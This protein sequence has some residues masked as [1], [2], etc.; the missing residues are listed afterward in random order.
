[1]RFSAAA[2][3]HFSIKSMQGS[4]NNAFI[5]SLGLTEW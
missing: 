2:P 3:T 5:K 1:M 4:M